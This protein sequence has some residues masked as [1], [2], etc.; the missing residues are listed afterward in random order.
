MTANLETKT[1]VKQ[2]LFDMTLHLDE[3]Q[4]RQDSS[5]KVLDHIVTFEEEK[6]MLLCKKIYVMPHSVELPDLT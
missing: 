6:V 2:I 3:K 5:Q 4:R 1:A